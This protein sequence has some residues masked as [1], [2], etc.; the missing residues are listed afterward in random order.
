VVLR[1]SL[2][3]SVYAHA[4]TR[5]A[6]LR[7]LA[8]G[9]LAALG[10]GPAVG[11]APAA[12]THAAAPT[13]ASPAAEV[14]WD[15]WGVPHIFAEDAPGLFF[16][17]G[18]TQAHAH[19][20]LLLRLYAQARGRGAEFFGP[21][22]LTVDRIVRTMGL[23]HRGGAWY[24]AQSPAFRA[25]LDAFAAGVNAYAAQHPERLDTAAKS[26]L[27]VDGTD[28]L[29]H[30][31]RIFF[32]FLGGESEVLDVLLGESERGS[33]GWAVAPSRAA[34]G[35][36]LLLANP[37]LPWGGEYTWFEAQLATPGVY[38]AY[39]ATLVGLPVLGIAFTDF[40]GWTH[41][42]NSL[43]AADLYRLTP[44]G[45]GY[46]F[47]GVTR[48]F[49]T[50]S[51]TIRVR[52]DDGTLR[53]ETLTVRRSV[54]GPVVDAGGELLAVRTAAVDE[55][56]S[57]AGVLEQWWDMARAT[58][59]GEFEAVLRRLQLPI[60]TVIYADRDGRVLSLFNG[61]VPVRPAGV[62]DWS[63]PVPGDTSA[64]LWT[65]IHPYEDLP[66]VVD[67]P[68]GWV[69][70]SNSPPWYTTYPLALDPDGYPPYMAP[71]DLGWRERRGIRMLEEHP[72]MSLE[73]MVE[74]KHSTRFELAD[75]VLDDLIAAARDS[76]DATAK[77]AADVLAAWDREA[78]PDSTGVILFV[79]WA[80]GFG[81]EDPVASAPRFATPPDPA[82]PLTT[83]AGLADPE[84]AVRVL[85]DAANEVEAIFGRLAVPWGEVARLQ[86]GTVDEPANGFFGEPFGVFRVLEVD[87]GRIDAGEPLPVEGG[88]SYVAA[89]EFAD[90]VRA[91]V[92]VAYGNASQP[93]SPHVG[94]QL[95]LAAKGE[96]RPA[97]RTRDE[98]EAHLEAR[99][100]VAAGAATPVPA[101]A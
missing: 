48:A 44:A 67:P 80:L 61:H 10:V 71:R 95:A 23:H 92:L 32:Q 91:Q 9:G 24:R 81:F 47:D 64:T 93:G 39:G 62:A 34:G 51:E 59:L 12:A 52:Q 45:D 83:P 72:A 36:A 75:R 35:H 63:E 87:F 99:E 8:G 41:T 56:S 20:D 14:L 55:W 57:A 33:N 68:G 17:F 74:L 78:N 98:I 94:D 6:L 46:R 60:F 13:G 4:L 16:G 85:I 66:R 97:W 49:D 2:T 65:A 86:G 73:Q 37:H 100:V 77:E 40:L 21:D 3:S 22:D 30:A 15:T 18:W 53:D 54:H 84:A 25:N 69:Q 76:G 19:G 31:A 43:D 101:P 96:L 50:R 88:D 82:A 26:V 70:N 90:P 1:R 89:V 27:P 28:V 5:R 42:V 11:V 79:F 58:N 29:A 7:R 38:D